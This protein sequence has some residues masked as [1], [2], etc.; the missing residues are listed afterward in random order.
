MVLDVHYEGSRL[1]AIV[2]SGATCNFI[3]PKAVNRLRMPWRKKKEVYQVYHAEGEPFTQENGLIERETDHLE[4]TIQDRKDIIPC[5]ILEVTEYEL[6]LGYPW[7]RDTNPDIDWSTGQLRWRNTES[8]P[9]DGTRQDSAAEQDSTMEPPSEP[10]PQTIKKKIRFKPEETKVIT[11]REAQTRGK[12]QQRRNRK[13]VAAIRMS[14]NKI[15]HMLQQKA[16]EDEDALAERLKKIPEEYHEFKK[17]FQENLDTKLP[18]H[19][20]WD[21][22]IEIIDGKQP[23]FSSIYRLSRDENIALKDY[24]ADMLAKG[25]IRESIS[26]AGAP[27]MFVPKKNGKLRLVVDYR[28]LNDITVKDRT[29]L[30]LISELRERLRGK[31]WFTAM[32]L[33]TGFNLI[34]IKEGHE[35]MTAFRTSE[36]LFEYLVLPMGLT[37]APAT[38]QRMI[39]NVLREYID[40]FCVVYLDDILI[41]SDTLEEHKEHVRKV[42]QKLQDND[43]LVQPDKCDFHTQ[44]VTFL[45][46]VIT[47]GK[48]HMEPCKIEAV[49]NWPVPK[50]VKEVQSFLGFANFYRRFIKGFSKIARVMHEVTKKDRKFLWLPDLQEAFDKLKEIITSDSVLLMFDPEKEIEL[51]TDASDYAL[52]AQLSQKDENGILRPVAFWSRSLQGP[53]LNYP[54]YDKEFLA[55]VDAFKEWRHW[56]QGS[57]HKVKVYTDHKNISYFATTQQLTGRQVRYAEALST[58]DYVLIHRKGSENGRADAL[59]RRPDYDKGPI[60]NKGQI[61][62]KTTEGHYQQIS[63]N[64]IFTV[65]EDDTTLR[66]IKEAC[67]GRSE[68]QFP[69][70]TEYDDEGRR[71]YNNK[72]WIPEELQDQVVKEMHQHPVHGHKGIRKTMQQIRQYFD[73]SGLKKK[74]QEIV[75]RCVTCGK[76]KTSKHKPYGELQPLPVPEKPWDSISMDF[77]VKLPKS[78]E[79]MTRTTYDSIWVIMDRLTKF[80]YMLP[81]KESSSAEDLAYMF[82]RTVFGNHGLPA[83]IISDRGSVFASKFWQSLMK[84]LGTNHKLSTAYHPQTDG[85]TERI[86]QIVEQYLRCYINNDQNDWVQWLPQAQFAYNTS[87][88]ESTELS[89]AYANSGYNPSAYRVPL[90][91]PNSEKAMIKAENLS[92]LHDEMKG[93]LEFIRD[94][95][96]KYADP[97]RLKTIFREGDMVYLHRF[98]PGKKTANIKTT[99]PS[100]KLDFKKLGPFKIKKVISEVTYELSLPEIIRIHPVFH[101]SL[102][103]KANVDKDSEP[104]LDEIEVLPVEEEYEVERILAEKTDENSERLYLVK[105][106]GC[107]ESENSWEPTEHLQNCQAKLQQFHRTLGVANQ[108]RQTLRQGHRRTSQH[109]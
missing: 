92:K 87:V 107:D 106:K 79:P 63:L 12:S 85:Q 57:M 19:K 45:G 16:P 109:H 54:I 46:H 33:K 22:A 39:N 55:I 88:S 27:V 77:I 66:L 21:H 80:A 37:N 64:L 28:R 108:H 35:W 13:A 105:W 7:L 47:P 82:L 56:L 74:V 8:D 17:V 59:S 15:D 44:K 60:T 4:F 84:Q 95:M 93:Q 91:G 104:T 23:G 68:E 81:Y 70:D 14:I 48:I 36:G 71:R 50:N 11:P 20:E 1:T 51:E 62:E 32:D 61:F 65:E 99:R 76:T 103:E 98:S 102:L 29:P 42:L 94:R 73:F 41:F 69:D 89:P 100:D 90:P 40:I 78:K 26:P 9:A 34:R 86:N 83:E 30:P 58:F 43:L 5:E 97:K 2:D 18:K 72:L 3:S 6:I 67:D 10:T 31:K 96:K 25:H 101:I 52:G 24:I 53:E 75:S 49:K 38:F